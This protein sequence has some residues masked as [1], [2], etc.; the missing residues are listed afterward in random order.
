MYVKELWRYP[1][2]SMAGER[3][4]EAEVTPLGLEG[5]RQVLVVDGNGRVV[6]SRTHPWLLGLRGTIANKEV[7]INGHPWKSAEAR[8]LMRGLELTYYAGPERFD[9]LPLLVTTDGAVAH[10]GMDGRRFRPNIVIGGV[11]GLAE[12]GWPGQKLRI[13][14]VEIEMAQLRGRCVMTTFDPDTL[15]QDRNVL[16]R[17]ARELDGTMGLDSAV[18]KAGRIRV[19]DLVQVV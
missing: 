10:M 5:D 3:L 15:E 19:G 8:E 2:K 12:R 6:S 17:I 7:L 13:G 18:G 14:E 11:E 16:K 4:E 1:V 9:V